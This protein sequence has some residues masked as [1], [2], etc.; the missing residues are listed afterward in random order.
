[1]F[2]VAHPPPGE[3]KKIYG[4]SRTFLYYP[5]AIIIQELCNGD[6][7]LIPSDKKQEGMDMMIG[8]A[9]DCMTS[10]SKILGSTKA[11]LPP[12]V[13]WVEMYNIMSKMC[14][15]KHLTISE[16]SIVFCPITDQNDLTNATAGRLL[17][18]EETC[19]PDNEFDTN[20]DS[21]ECSK[22]YTPIGSTPAVFWMYPKSSN[23]LY[24][25]IQCYVIE[26]SRVLE[27]SLTYCSAAR[28][29]SF[30]VFTAYE[31]VSQYLSVGRCT[32]TEGYDI[33]VSPYY[34]VSQPATINSTKF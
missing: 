23:H 17:F 29:E 6:F 34:S 9:A 24:D 8:C 3:S 2:R 25:H 31:I 7:V 10:T 4:V 11:T 33:P 14:E 15:N 28:Q 18:R 5:A 26:T 1:M 30:L 22:C 27:F 19:S 21:R 12:N 20:F 13:P 32:F 16:Q